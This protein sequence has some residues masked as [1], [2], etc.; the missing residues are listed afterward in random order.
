MQICPCFEGSIVN[1]QSA[2]TQPRTFTKKYIVSCRGVLKLE[3]P[4][5]WYDRGGPA[6]VE[7][8]KSFLF[9]ESYVLVNN[10]QHR[11]L[12]LP[13]SNYCNCFDLI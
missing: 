7:A 5:P 6:K 10:Y 4:D 12:W 1:T 11:M 8:G 9:T 2:N 13:M 3:G